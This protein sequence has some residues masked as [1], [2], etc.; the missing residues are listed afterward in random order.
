LVAYASPSGSSPK[1]PLRSFNLAPIV[2]AFAI[3][4]P[5]IWLA[6]HVSLQ[7]LSSIHLDAIFDQLDATMRVLQGLASNWQTGDGLPLQQLLQIQPLVEDIP[8]HIS[9]F[10][11]FTLW[12]AILMLAWLS[13]HIVLVIPAGLY[14]LFD[15]RRQRR[16]LRSAR[17]KQMDSIYGSSDGRPSLG[18]RV[19][20][21]VN[22]RFPNHEVYFPQSSEPVA[23]SSHLLVLEKMCRSVM[24]STTFF[25]CALLGLTPLAVYTIV[26]LSEGGLGNLRILIKL[27]VVSLYVAHSLGSEC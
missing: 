25:C 26:R 12:W 4:A 24:I 13:M 21:A 27:E 23:E 17:H 1:Y 14:Q 15:L 5:A 6:A 20:S 9:Q 11:R 10:Q 2:N 22:V 7:T 3:L 8:H 19:K 16:Q 18:Q